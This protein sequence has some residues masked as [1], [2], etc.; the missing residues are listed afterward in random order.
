MKITEI[1]YTRGAT[2]NRGNFNSE[3]FELSVTVQVTDETTPED[4]YVRASNWVTERIVAQMKA[5]SDAP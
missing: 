3:R 5:K 4:A 1:T 2:V